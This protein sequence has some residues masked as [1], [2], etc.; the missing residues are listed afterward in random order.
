MLLPQLL[1]MTI[2]E[3]LR[4]NMIASSFVASTEF[5]DMISS[6]PLYSSPGIH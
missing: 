1:R 2:L 6:M 4:Q 3:A 5:V